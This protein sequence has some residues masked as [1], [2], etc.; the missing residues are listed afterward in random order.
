MLNPSF[1]SSAVGISTFG[2]VLNVTVPF[3]V[4]AGLS[5][6]LL[7]AMVN[8]PNSAPASSADWNGTSMTQ[9]SGLT[10]GH[11]WN[12]AFYILQPESGAFDLS[13]NW[14]VFSHDIAVTVVLIEN[15]GAPDNSVV[16]SNSTSNVAQDVFTSLNVAQN[17]SMLVEWFMGDALQHVNVVSFPSQTPITNGATAPQSW[18][19]QASYKINSSPGAQAMDVSLDSG[20]SN[21]GIY[22]VSVLTV[23]PV[24][25]FVTLTTSETATITDTFIL[26]ALPG[27]SISASEFTQ[28][29][30]GNSSVITEIVGVI[31]FLTIAVVTPT[32]QPL[33]VSAFDQ[34]VMD[35]LP[36]YYENETA[37]NDAVLLSIISPPPPPGPTLWTNQLRNTIIP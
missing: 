35:D 31:E 1:N 28:V 21:G 15:A 32:V 8:N 18:T 24:P 4:P 9:V 20:G 29:V 13:V 3:T 26:P 37:V 36:F 10:S 6:T 22:Q 11:F 33:L 5:N 7:I 19:Y 2:S 17:G 34:S 25:N 23:P 12:K 16:N 14:S 30:D 27:L